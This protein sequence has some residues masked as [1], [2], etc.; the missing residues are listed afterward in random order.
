MSKQSAA[1]D[2]KNRSR[3]VKGQKCHNEQKRLDGKAEA[4]AVMVA[5][6]DGKKTTTTKQTKTGGKKRKKIRREK[7]GSTSNK[8]QN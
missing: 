4:A 3:K 5:R 8:R 2:R 7:D 1:M 6:L